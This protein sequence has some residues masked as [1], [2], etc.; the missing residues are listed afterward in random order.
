MSLKC[1]ND[2]LLAVPSLNEIERE[3]RRRSYLEWLCAN[4]PQTW[5]VRGVD[6]IRRI[7]TEIDRVLRGEID[8]LAIAMPPRHAKTE[9]TTVRLPAR[10]LDYD[11]TASILIV[12]YNERFARKLSRKARA[13]AVTA[14]VELSAKNAQD[15]WETTAGGLVMARGIGSPPTGTG[16]KYILIDDPVRSREDVESDLKREKLK[17]SYADDFFT[18]LEPDGAIVLVQTRW[19]HD[20]LWPFAVGQEPGRWTEMVMPAISENGKALWPERFPISVLEGIKQVLTRE[21]GSYGFEALYQQNPTPREGAMFK[22]SAFQFVDRHEVPEI[23]RSAWYWDLAITAGAGDYTCGV[24]MGVGSDGNYYILRV[25]RGQWSGAK[26]DE[27]ILACAHETGRSVPVWGP[28][29]PGQAGV[30]AAQDFQRKL[31][32]FSTR[33]FRESGSKSVRAA[34]YASAVEREAVYLVRGPWTTEFIEEHRT[35]PLGKHD[36]QVDAAAN[37]FNGLHSGRTGQL[38]G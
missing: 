27:T 23:V 17:E 34:P 31:A 38:I 21:Y 22:V 18:R 4:V 26:R 37:V 19:H 32:G 25:V 24:L 7:S 30:V 5:M 16:F 13:V 33:I 12:G 36:D 8:R 11:P 3:V 10:I 20:D 29:D 15:E 35:F 28:Q 9:T 1:L 2:S 6:H 14:G